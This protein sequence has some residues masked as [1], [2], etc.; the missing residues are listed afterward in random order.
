MSIEDDRNQAVTVFLQAMRPTIE[1][2]MRQPVEGG[3]RFR[4]NHGQV[5]NSMDAMLG[6]LEIELG[7]MVVEVYLEAKKERMS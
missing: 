2:E 5:R 3:A 4:S 1:E 6:E 7:H